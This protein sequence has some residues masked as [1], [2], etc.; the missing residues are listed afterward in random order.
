M[1][2]LFPYQ[3]E[4]VTWIKPRKV[5]LLGL[6]MGLGKT[7]VVIQAGINEL[8]LRR[9]VIVCPAIARLSWEREIGI[10][11]NVPDLKIRILEKRSDIPNADD[12][13]IICSFD[14]V[15]NNHSNLSDF[16]PSLL[17]VDE[18]HYLKSP[19]SKRTKAVL[20][21][22]GIV[23]RSKKIWFLTGTPMPN[24]PGE[25]WACLHV[26]GAT[27]LNYDEFVTKYCD[28]YVFNGQKR[29]IGS[30]ILAM[31]QL[32][33]VMSEVMLRQKAIEVLKELPITRINPLL[34][35]ADLDKLT[36]EVAEQFKELERFLSFRAGD[37][38]PLQQLSALEAVA[39]SI[40]T[41]RRYC[42]M[43]KLKPV[44]ELIAEELESRAYE[45]II[46]FCV[47]REAVIDATDKLKKFGAV[48]IY[49]ETP[50][51]TRQEHIDAFQDP[52]SKVKVL[53]ANIGTAGTNINLTAAHQIVFLEQSFVPGDNAQA[54]GRA[55]RIG[56]KNSVNVRIASLAN[57][58]DEKVNDILAR[59]TKEILE[60]L[61]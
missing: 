25:L 17:V 58:I 27:K 2:Q 48:C 39:S 12:E 52:N 33:R 5:A 38:N 3:K 40:S 54:I 61:G 60:L 29:I 4:A 10:W 14:Y 18:A 15:T 32:K 42:V 49:G 9:I 1:L 45:K 35:E 59:K 13:V 41:L 36:P 24:H 6:E 19:E 34:I 53:V 46:I 50:A 44:C 20:G 31:P 22:G 8:S 11:S 57:T 28:Y 21:K 37:L 26:F 7:A 51:R 23:H 16:S 43:K 47:H 30:K 56:Q 55:A